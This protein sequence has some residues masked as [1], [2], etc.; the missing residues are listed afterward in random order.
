MLYQGR[1]TANIS[2]PLGGIGSGS[3]GLSG[4][5]E[6]TDWE[7]FNRPNKNS[8]NGYTH[9]AI[10]ASNSRGSVTK[11]LQGDTNSSLLGS[12]LGTIHSGFG[13]GPAGITMA[14]F[15]HFRDVSFDGFFPFANLTFNDE[16]FPAEVRLCAFNPLIPH[17]EY[18]SSL[19]VAF[20]EWEI[21]N[22]CDEKTEFSLIFNVQNPA[23]VSRNRAISDSHGI[24]LSCA[25]KTPAEIGYTELCI[26]SDAE[27]TAVTEYWHR[28]HWMDPVTTYWKNITE[29]GR[30]PE[31]S[32]AAAREDKRTEFQD[33]GTLAAYVTLG[34]K[35]KKKLRFVLSWNI[36]NQYNYW[37]AYKD[38]DGNDIIW[39]NYYATQFKCAEDSAKYALS[40]FDK[41]RTESEAFA[42]A[43]RESSIP[44]SAKDAVSANL[45]VLKSATVLRLEDGRFWAWEGVSTKS[46][47]CEG[48]CQHVWAYAY[49][50]AFLFPRLER[51]L[52]DTT[53]D[54]ALKESGESIFRVPLPLGRK[55]ND[56]RPC[57]DGQMSEVIKCYREWKFSGDS[58][59]LRQR[60]E[61]IFSMLEFAWSEENRDG[62]DSDCDGVLEGRQHH[63]LDMELFGPSSWLQGFYLLALDCGARM[64]DAL[65]E[66]ERAEKYRK[67][68]ENGKAWTNEKLFNGEY[69]F[70]KVDLNDKSIIDKF[71]AA[72]YWSDEAGEIK[73]Q[74][75]EGSIID[76]MLADYHANL[77]G[78]PCIF[79]KDK[80]DKALLSL[81]KYNFKPSMRGVTNMW[82]NFAVNDEAGTVICSYPD[83]RREPFIPVP[84]CEECMTGF[85]Y[86]LAA[87]MIAEGKTEMGETLVKAVRDRYDGE[88]RNPW[89]EIEC[90]SNYARS[91]ASF[92]LLPIYSGFSF[93]MTKG[94]LGFFPLTDKDS[95]FMFSVKNSYGT[96][97]F[98]GKTLTL[99]LLGA[100]LTLSEFG[101]RGTATGLKI[102]GEE[103]EFSR[104]ESSSCFGERTVCRTLELKLL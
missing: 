94:Y 55:P 35:E 100:P 58:E 65:G 73:Y 76:Q 46:G 24:V 62:W 80:K 43:I 8:R 37:S 10:K 49:S 6:L 48:T 38:D 22:S 63:T 93:D 70:H 44:E 32:Y 82:R 16:D 29:C 13:F 45:S 19:P 18:N 17:D 103:I 61:K 69:F 88:G 21:E 75:A 81:Y 91:M 102:D 71:G 15:P 11:V 50:L 1:K 97:E 79:D 86:A 92:S 74:V 20:F 2:F 39:K 53:M 40:N 66:T 68:Y 77:I 67:I 12:N 85:E 59:W 56:F 99:T 27:D 52:R 89:N 51:S 33:H 36:P 41:L 57:L 34:A 30:L 26:L 25:D 87:L 54:Y 104:G 64:A 101:H 96:V 72:N 83:G 7:I 14:G 9:F 4:N 90:G 84:Y 42:S 60:S 31:R 98:S 78:L 5:G 95:K 47:S 3:I 28:G 23:P